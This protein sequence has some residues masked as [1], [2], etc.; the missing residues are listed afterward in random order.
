[1]SETKAAIVLDSKIPSPSYG[2]PFSSFG[3]EC[4][5]EK[6]EVKVGSYRSKNQRVPEINLHFEQ[7]FS[8]RNE[9]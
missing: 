7:R 6:N 5:N 3:G 4:I 2:I 1:M 9:L 8:Q